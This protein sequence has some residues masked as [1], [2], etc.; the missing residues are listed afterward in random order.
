M[1]KIYDRIIED[2]VK[3]NEVE[4][5]KH[6]DEFKEYRSPMIQYVR[7]RLNVYNANFNAVFVGQTGSG[8]SWASIKFAQRIDDD[9][10]VNRIIF[11]IKDYLTLIKD[12]KIGRGNCVIFD[13]AGVGVNAKMWYSIVNKVC[14][15]TFQ[16]IRNYNFATLFT[17]P[18]TSY[19]DK[20]IRK[21]FHALFMSE[22]I[23]RSKNQS[24]FKILNPTY[25]IY[26][27]K[28][29]FYPYSFMLNNVE[30]RVS[31][32]KFNKP[33]IKLVRQYEAKKLAFQN[34]LYAKSFQ[35]IYDEKDSESKQ[36]KRQ[37]RINEF[38]E[39]IQR[40]E[41]IMDRFIKTTKSGKRS[42]SLSLLQTQLGYSKSMATSIKVYLQEKWNL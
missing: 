22:R 38:K 24:V 35:D 9:F 8:K 2:E 40:V 34:E 17:T 12:K 20:S 5:R 14:S 13:E 4:F 10:N 25:N 16:T 7:R 23:I 27:D 26:K 39:E 33:N 6:A 19:I 21:L 15:T 28:E 31:K 11:S 1:N 3:L 37:K 32:M 36:E 42:I 41:P 29:E 18:F 30:Y